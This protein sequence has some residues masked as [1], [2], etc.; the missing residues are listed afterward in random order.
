MKVLIDTNILLD[1]LLER[2]PFAKDAELLLKLVDSGQVTAYVT[3]TTL[4]DIF[5]IVR[6]QTKKVQVAK[7][8]IRTILETLEVEEVERIVLER[9]LELEIENFEDGL[10]ASCAL[11]YEVNGIVTRDKTGFSKINIPALAISDLYH[12]VSQSED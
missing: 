5:Y 10:Q 4:T 11:K 9:A 8:A 1:A 12:L 6:R 3:A 2:E 7:Q